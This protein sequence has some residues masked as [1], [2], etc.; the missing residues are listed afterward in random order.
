MP[1]VPATWMIFRRL[2]SDGCLRFSKFQR[3]IG[4]CIWSQL[5]YGI[6]DATE[7]DLHLVDRGWIRSNARLVSRLQSRKG[8]LQG[9]E[10]VDRILE[11]EK[12]ANTRFCEAMV[13]G[14]GTGWQKYIIGAGSSHNGARLDASWPAEDA[15]DRHKPASAHC[16]IELRQL[17][18]SA[19]TGLFSHRCARAR[20]P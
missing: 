1:L 11:V 2:R 13:R 10:R 8:R 3:Q 5:T 6:A 9:I 15:S 17:P 19:Q 16:A 4:H 14:T 7:A 18:P 12:S 20:C